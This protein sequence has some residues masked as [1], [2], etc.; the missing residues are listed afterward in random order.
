MI[1]TALAIAQATVSINSNLPGPYSISAAGPCG[2]IVDFYY[3]ALILAGVLAFGAIVFGGVKYAISAGNPSKQSEGRSWIWGALIGLLLLGAAWLILH[4]INPNLTQCSLP[5]LSGV[6]I[7]AG[8]GNGSNGGGTQIT[9]PGCGG[10]LCSTLPNCT[11]VAGKTNCGGAQGMVSLLNCIN[12]SDPNYAVNEGYPPIGGHSDPGHNN[13]CAIDV[14]VANCQAGSQFMNAANS[15][16]ASKVL[17]EYTSCGGKSFSHTT[18][19][20][21]HIDAQS[22]VGGC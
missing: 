8:I 2:W 16:G 3:T 15:C 5:T 17:N 19:G 22:G 12:Q 7:N 20:N 21:I 4:T 11:P 10:G 18:G 14:H 1:N 13:G 6:N 9:G